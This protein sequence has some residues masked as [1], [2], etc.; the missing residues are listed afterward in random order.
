MLIKN[1]ETVATRKPWIK[2]LIYGQ[3]GSG[4]TR[5]S[6]DAPNPFWFDFESSSE[7][8]RHWPDYKNIPVKKPTSID[9]LRL[10]VIKAVDDATIDTIVIDSITSGLDYYLRQ[11][12]NKVASKRDRF[13]IYEADY[14][15]STSVF[16]ELFTILQDVNLHVIII[17][18]ARTIR[19]TESGHIT[20]I[21]PDL[22]PRLQQ[23]LT[24]LV[25]VVGYMQVIPSES[26]GNSRRLYLNPTKQ[27]EAKNRLNI[28]E[29]YIEN[30][31]WKE[32][33]GD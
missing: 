30:P 6:A 3:A 22:T 10:D 27:I 33:F 28:Q 21:Y 5:F 31:T 26:K 16:G 8:L 11:H 29:T 13:Q 9:E 17:G 19:D 32:I 2:A 25:N 4:K 15:Y 1:A 18:H 14:K 7:T 24:R 12:M 20:G 23:N